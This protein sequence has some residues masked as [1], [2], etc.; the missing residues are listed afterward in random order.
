MSAIGAVAA[1]P[2]FIPKPAGRHLSQSARRK[3][4]ERRYV[5]ESGLAAFGI[6]VIESR[7]S[8]SVRTVRLLCTLE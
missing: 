7:H 8:P 3:P 5:V 6:E 4:S 1:C 2:H